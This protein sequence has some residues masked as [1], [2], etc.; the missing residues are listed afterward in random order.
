MCDEYR[1]PFDR[2]EY[3]AFALVGALCALVIGYTA[4]GRY[5]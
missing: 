3:L 2:L 5:W 4:F 1:P